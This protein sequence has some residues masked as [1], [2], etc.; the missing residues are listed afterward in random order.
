MLRF[1]VVTPIHGLKRADGSREPIGVG[2]VINL[3]FDGQATEL[4][5]AGAVIAS[6]A[7]ITCQL[8]WGDGFS[9][10]DSPSDAAAL[11]AALSG[12]GAIVFFPGDGLPDDAE[13]VLSDFS[14]D[15]LIAELDARRE[16]GRLR[17]VWIGYD[18]GVPIDDL[19]PVADTANNEDAGDRS[20]APVSEDTPPA[21]AQ[22]AASEP[23]AES[24]P[25]KS[26]RRP[27]ATAK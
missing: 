11:A 24:A 23:V 18:P 10:A 16:E 21:P 7:D 12:L 5:A 20:A 25:A 3:P 14:N 19:T 13:I 8:V 27:K 9:P 26:T 15:Q 22:P 1:E 6:E 17:P 2:A 4:I